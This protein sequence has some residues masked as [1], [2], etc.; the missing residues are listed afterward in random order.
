MFVW[1]IVHRVQWEWEKNG[2]GNMN[3]KIGHKPKKKRANKM[4]WMFLFLCLGQLSPLAE[5]H[6]QTAI[7]SCFLCYNTFS[8]VYIFNSRAFTTARKKKKRP[9]CL[10]T[11]SDKPLWQQAGCH[12]FNHS[13]KMQTISFPFNFSNY[14]RLSIP[15]R[16]WFPI[17]FFTLVKF[18]RSFFL[19]KRKKYV[20]LFMKKKKE[21]CFG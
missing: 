16:P 12:S 10:F 18:K 5:M 14:I 3:I 11:L 4:K 8:T 17:F 21:K 19:F 1:P 7:V 2:G 20:V 15:Q 13:L 6:K 9:I